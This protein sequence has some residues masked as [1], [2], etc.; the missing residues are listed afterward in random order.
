MVYVEVGTVSFN[1][2]AMARN[3]HQQLLCVLKISRCFLLLAR[4]KMKN[5]AMK[6]CVQRGTFGVTRHGPL[7]ASVA[8]GCS[9]E[10][11]SCAPTYVTSYGMSHREH[12]SVGTPCGPTG[13]KLA[14]AQV[15]LSRAQSAAS[16]VDRHLVIRVAASLISVRESM[17]S[18]VTVNPT[19]S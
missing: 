12:L 2:C 16:P 8:I 11:I 19:K 13:A 10:L 5:I 6:T 14:E 17:L 15:N 3:M 4:A 9:E 1:K 7:R 18:A